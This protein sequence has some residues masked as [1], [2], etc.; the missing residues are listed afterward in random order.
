MSYT[1]LCIAELCVLGFRAHQESRDLLDNL[2]RKAL[3][4]QLAFLALKD[5][6]VILVLM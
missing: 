5:P 1:F 6:V 3:Q 2:E 4:V